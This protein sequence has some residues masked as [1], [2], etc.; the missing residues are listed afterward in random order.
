MGLGWGCKPTKKGT[1]RK[2]QLRKSEIE[3][4]RIRHQVSKVGNMNPNTNK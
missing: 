2:R 1:K 4:P 3:R